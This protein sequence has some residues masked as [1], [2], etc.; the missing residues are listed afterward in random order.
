MSSVHPAFNH[1]CFTSDELWTS[2]VIGAWSW[3]IFCALGKTDFLSPRENMQ[4]KYIYSLFQL[5]P[6]SPSIGL[7]WKLIACKISLLLQHDAIVSRYCCHLCFLR[8]LLPPGPLQGLSRQFSSHLMRQAF[9]DDAVQNS[10]VPDV[11][12]FV[13]DSKTDFFYAALG[14]KA[15]MRSNSSCGERV[16]CI[17]KWKHAGLLWHSYLHTRPWK[18][19]WTG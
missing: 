2:R 13:V 16:H 15:A 5:L 11:V 8:S 14:S 10:P 3:M 17:P 1:K 12:K 18:L 4:V 6:R 9:H 7:D 19:K